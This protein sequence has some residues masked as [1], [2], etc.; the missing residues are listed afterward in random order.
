[1]KNFLKKASI[2]IIIMVLIAG[3]IFSL[4]YYYGQKI[5]DEVEKEISEIA[6]KNNY[7][8]RFVEVE[9]N[10]LL[11]EMRLQNLNLI[12]ADRFNLIV[13]LAEINL[14][15]QQ[16]LNY[17]RHQ[18]FQLDK[19]F[20]STVEQ[21]NYSNLQDNYQLNLSDTEINYQG[22]LPREIM[23]EISSIDG[24]HL[25]LNDN[26]KL[27]LKAA[28]VKYDFPYY[29]SYGLNN[30]DWNR[31]STFNNF[32]MRANYSQENQQL[33]ITE[34]NLNGDLLKIIFNLKAGLYYNQQNEKISFTQLQGDYDFLLEAEDLEFEAN[35]YFKKLNFN[36]FD[37][38]GS[39]DLVRK[40]ENLQAN[41]LDFNLNLSSFELLLSE[42]LSQQ[43]NQNTFGI[44]AADN[45]FELL[46]DNFTYQQ[47]YSYPSGSSQS[48][49]DSSLVKAELEAEYN[50]KQ[51]VPY[52]S[53]G[54]LR[55]QPQTATA[56]QFNSFLQLV[57]NQRLKQDEQGYY[58][59]EFWGKINDLNFE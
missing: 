16:I 23:T 43:L 26:H 36:Q 48:S 15:W 4:N 35:S 14:S 42:T 59:L 51:D 25:L 19:N 58:H 17:I 40:E 22:N 27:V 37:F 11:Q 1:M 3:I 47:N 29:R 34:F 53:S 39:L 5:S 8:L 31:L 57:L 54:T 55:Y 30:E 10:P 41:Q 38:K 7:Q 50:Y 6:E 32:V 46:I 56:K 20:V 28:K 45:K 9:T 49:L 21:I 12:R 33:N 2:Y 24:L 44:L 18:N 52:V 13:N